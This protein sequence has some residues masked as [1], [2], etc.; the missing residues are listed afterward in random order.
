MAWPLRYVE[1]LTSL[2]TKPVAA[3]TLAD[4]VVLL[5]TVAAAGFILFMVF[6]TAVGLWRTT[7]RYG[8]SDAATP[9]GRAVPRAPGRIAMTDAIATVM[10][11]AVVVPLLLIAGIV[12]MPAGMNDL[13]GRCA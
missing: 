7:V 13:I 5:S 3:W 2:W 6:V 11:G 12:I 4:I 10:S 1:I 9:D 8:A